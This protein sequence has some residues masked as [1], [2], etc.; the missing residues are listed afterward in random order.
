MQLTYGTVYSH[1]DGMNVIM[2]GTGYKGEGNHQFLPARYYSDKTIDTVR[3][4]IWQVLTE[5]RDK[6]TIGWFG[7]GD[8][9]IVLIMPGLTRGEYHYSIVKG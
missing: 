8:R 2:P 4:A 9:L 5:E 3:K 1:R 6:G 7:K